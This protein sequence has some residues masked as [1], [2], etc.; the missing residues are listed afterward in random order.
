MNL[1][2]INNPTYIVKLD[3]NQSVWHRARRISQDLLEES[4]TSI[5]LP[6]NKISIS[7]GLW[8]LASEAKQNGYN[9]RWNDIE[10]TSKKRLIEDFKWADQLWIYVI[11]PTLNSCLTLARTAKDINPNLKILMGGPHTFSV[12]SD[13]LVENDFIDIVATSFQPSKTIMESQEYALKFPG[14]LHN[15]NGI[16]VKY[17]NH[18][19]KRYE[20]FIDPSVLNLGLNNYHINISTTFGC[21]NS[22]KYCVSGLVPVKYRKIENIKDELKIYK[23]LL[24]NKSLIHFSDS[25]FIGN[26]NYATEI[27]KFIKN[28]VSSL[29]YSCDING[30][31]IQDD[32]LKLLS[33]SKFK[34]I[35][36]GFETSDNDVLKFN[37]K[38]NRFENNVKAALKIRKFLKNGVIKAYWLLGLPGSTVESL[39]SDYKIIKFLL[40][41]NI[42]DVVSPKLFIPY[43]GTDYYKNPNNY[44]IVINTNDFS[45]YDRHNLPPI[46]N[47]LGVE[48]DLLA[49]YLTEIDKLICQMYATR[50]NMG[51]DD[52]IKH[53]FI[54]KRY[55]GSLYI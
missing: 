23:R 50:L 4:I 44:G 31:N 39:E 49:N 38:K 1:L 37:G 45:K 29:T 2:F 22:C 52:I 21:I 48:A 51:I 35:S 14:S 12:E 18:N 10:I 53:K 11:T 17:P 3:K 34:Y 25:N 20:E 42:V 33:K 32:L 54:P 46:C 24:E 40:S 15:N 36:I 8:L 19:N 28:E 30:D 6:P 9:V 7:R 5:Q 47:P 16:I 55:T 13:F 43:P 27:C 26:N 41:E